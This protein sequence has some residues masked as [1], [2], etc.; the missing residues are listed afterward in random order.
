MDKM[1]DEL[2]NRI[3]DAIEDAGMPVRTSL[4]AVHLAY[5]LIAAHVAKECAEI[6][7]GM[8]VGFYCAEA[9]ERKFGVTL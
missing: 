2:H 6:C 1:S 5:P 7:R 3:A 4:V 8:P 9:I